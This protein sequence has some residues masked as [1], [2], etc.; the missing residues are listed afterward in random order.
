VAVT[1]RLGGGGIVK[2]ADGGTSSQSR[3]VNRARGAGGVR[4]VGGEA[5]A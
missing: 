1:A 3:V 2:G 5:V 4:G